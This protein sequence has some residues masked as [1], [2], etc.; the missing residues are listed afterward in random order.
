MHFAFEFRTN[1]R[2]PRLAV[3]SGL[4][5]KCA[6]GL[7]HPSPAFASSDCLWV[8]PPRTPPPPPPL[9]LPLSPLGL[10]A[11]RKASRPCGGRRLHE[12]MGNLNL[13][14]PCAMLPMG[15]KPQGVPSPSSYYTPAKQ[16]IPYM[17]K[18]IQTITLHSR[19]DSAQVAHT[20][21]SYAR[22]L[23]LCPTSSF[24]LSLLDDSPSLLAYRGEREGCYRNIRP[25]LVFQVPVCTC[26]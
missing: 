14:A 9:P 3:R 1:S 21:V 12:V 7:Y 6:K 24:P 10:L 8:P 13:M 4:S 25:S 11:F 5:L 23:G 20:P 15:S 16:C 2:E 19:P 26:R 17:L 18:S 22:H